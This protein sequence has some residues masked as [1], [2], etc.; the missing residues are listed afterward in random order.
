MQNGSNARRTPWVIAVCAA[1]LAFGAAPRALWA[2]QA[3]AAASSAYSEIEIK[4]ALLY[5]FGGY[6]EWPTSKS[7]S[8]PITFAVLNAPRIE[9][10]LERLVRGRTLQDRPVRVRRLR[11]INDLQGEEVVFIGSG[12]NW[13]LAQLIGAI[14]GPTLIVTDATE[15]LESGSMINFQLVDERVRFEV[16]LPEA[17]AAG[18]TLSS[19]LL[20]AALRVETTRC[21][22][23]CRTGSWARP[24][25]SSI[26]HTPSRLDELKTP[27][28]S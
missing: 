6:V 21:W 8:E 10:A 14:E 13:R 9:E 12:E 4:A 24:M 5:N 27:S 20:S 2:Q 3:S 26:R 11:S 18:L 28:R 25:L 23:E 19:R 17:Q 22:I 1:A 7:S 16:A 15:G